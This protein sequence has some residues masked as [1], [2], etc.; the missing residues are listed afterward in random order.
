MKFEID[1]TRVIND[2]CFCNEIHIW[3]DKYMI[4]V[5]ILI[6]LQ[7]TNVGTLRHLNKSFQYIHL[8]RLI[9]IITSQHNPWNKHIFFPSAV[10]CL[11]RKEFSAR[12][13]RKTEEMKYTAKMT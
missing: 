4:N 13:S 10:M 6:Y 9:L 1:M 2:V 11:E 7:C 5:R 12:L 8:R 3:Y